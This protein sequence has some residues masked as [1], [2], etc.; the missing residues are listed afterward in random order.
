[1]RLEREIAG[2][3]FPFAA[4]IMAAIA[5]GTSTLALTALILT[6]LLLTC[7][8]RKNWPSHLQWGL[9]CLCTLACGSFIG[10]SAMELQISRLE[11]DGWIFR[12]AEHL[13]DRLKSMIDA[14]AFENKETNALVK[15]LLTGD[16]SD[17]GAETTTIFRNSGASHILALSGLHLG[18]IYGVLS[19]CLSL[20]GNKP[21]IRKIRAVLILLTCGLYTLCTG[22]G[23][24]ITRAFTFIALREMAIMTGRYAS[25][26]S[27]LAVSLMLQLAFDP[28]AATEVGFQLSYAAMFGIAYIFPHLRRLWGEG[29][30]GLKWIWESAMLSISCQLTTGPL[31]YHY[32][33]T[34]PQYFIL[35]NLLALPLAGII[36]PTSLL[37]VILSTIGLCPEFLIQGTEILTRSL[38][39]VL[40]TISSM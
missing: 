39:Q 40:S 18:I 7:P 37:T 11:S 13:G 27:I 35:T 10:S 4:G 29:W 33:G 9:L 24:S 2:I 22:A 30:K 36:I 34:L 19:K 20:S 16:R 12:T 6:V 23:A 21:G 1:M 3:A 14:I 5:V 31:A 28:T 25:L 38:T 26:K 8:S 32:F 15:A 17:I